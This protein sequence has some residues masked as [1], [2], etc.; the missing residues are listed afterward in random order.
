MYRASRFT[1]REI[2]VQV[3]ED[4]GEQDM[5][6][7]QEEEDMVG[8]GVDQ[9]QE[10][11]VTVG[12]ADMQEAEVMDIQLAEGEDISRGREVRGKEDVVMEDTED[13]IKVVKHN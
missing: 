9:V 7:V 4:M 13:R 11:M 1:I 3:E 2:G 5:D 12:L 10:E 6:R 8:Q